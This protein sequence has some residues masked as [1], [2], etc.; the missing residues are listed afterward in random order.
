MSEYQ[1]YEFQTIDRALTAEQQA[2]MRKLSKRVALS[3]TR[4]A[5][6][7]SYGDFP[8]EPLEVL[9]QPFDALCSIAN[10]GSKQ[11]AF[12]FPRGTLV[13]EQLQPYL[14]RDEDGYVSNL[15]VQCPFLVMRHHQH[16][17]CPS[18]SSVC[19]PAPGRALLVGS[20]R[21]CNRRPG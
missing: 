21:R 8:G 18:R 20:R 4:A 14:L 7:Y 16:G 19:N 2:I 9:E 13:A 3:A 1:Y 11:L 17:A 5:F 10:W 6:N 12:C 15:H